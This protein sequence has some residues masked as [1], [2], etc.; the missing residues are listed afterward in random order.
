MKYVALLLLVVQNASLILSMRKAK[1]SEGDQF[2]STV[3]VVMA[4]VLKLLTCLAVILY[5]KKG[6]LV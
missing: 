5:E 2:H 1:T 3:A 4:E 6:Q